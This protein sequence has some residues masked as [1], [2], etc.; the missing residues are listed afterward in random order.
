MALATFVITEENKEKLTQ[1][2]YHARKTK[3]RIINQLI[4]QAKQE[5][6]I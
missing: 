1:L 6:L 5:E 4:Q 2:S 3:S